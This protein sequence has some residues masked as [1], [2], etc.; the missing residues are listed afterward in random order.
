MFLLFCVMGLLGCF[1]SR[2]REGSAVRSFLNFFSFVLL[3]IE[4][5]TNTKNVRNT[6][7][8]IAPKHRTRFLFPSPV[9][10]E[11]RS[12]HGIF[13]L[14]LLP[15]PSTLLSI[16]EIEVEFEEL[17]LK[18]VEFLLIFPILAEVEVEVEVPVELVEKAGVKLTG[19]HP[20]SPG[21]SLTSP[22]Y[23]FPFPPPLVVLDLRPQHIHKSCIAPFLA[24]GRARHT[25]SNSV[26]GHSL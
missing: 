13:P 24:A 10:K 4:K 5:T 11:R 20:L 9:I 22:T 18:E 3:L 15:F 26:K 7:P 12:M 21:K 16:F 2:D 8:A 1:I 17:G 25:L 6:I 14:P 23:P 19:H